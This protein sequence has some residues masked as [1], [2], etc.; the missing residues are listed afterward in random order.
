VKLGNG[1]STSLWYDNWCSSSPLINYLTPRDISREAFLLTNTVADLV[2]NGTWSWPNSWL[3]K[4]PDLDL[5]TC[6]ALVSLV[7]DLWQWRDRNG[8]ISS[9][10][11]AKDWEAEKFPLIL[12]LY[13]RFF[14]LP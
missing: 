6:P 4:A 14:S 13:G 9:F 5:I 12:S 1:N 10:P 8:N 2:S 3:L 7:A 11:V